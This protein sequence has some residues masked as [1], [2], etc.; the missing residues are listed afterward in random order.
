MRLHLSRI[1]KILPSLINM[2]VRECELDDL[3][4]DRV[5][6]A[7]N[8]SLRL[9]R[10]YFEGVLSSMQAKHLLQIY[11]EESGPVRIKLS[12]ENMKSLEAQVIH[13]AF[14]EIDSAS[15]LEIDIGE[16][17]SLFNGRGVDFG[18]APDDVPA[19][20]RFVRVD[21]NNH[22]VIEAT[23]LL[24]NLE[25]ELTARNDLPMDAD[26][27]R[28]I[29]SEI[30][31]LL[32]VIQEKSIRLSVIALSISANGAL[33]YLRGQF[34][35]HALAGLTGAIIAALMKAFGVG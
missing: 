33:G 1:E 15:E 25:V 27:A 13:N 3:D 29:L 28:A 21:H 14:S 2:I 12:L 4:K 18:E 30:R 26:Q 20:D 7:L 22:D 8:A 16:I 11:T 19:S 10:P 6:K 35:E 23:T 31:G 32:V 9:S 5:F 17:L 34:A 24:G